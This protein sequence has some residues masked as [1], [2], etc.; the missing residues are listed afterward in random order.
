M[1]SEIERLLY[2]A[3]DFVMRNFRSGAARAAQKRRAQRKLG[4]VLRR[5][6]R[7]G[8]LLV[9]ILAG[10]VAYSIIVAPI[11]LLTWLVAIP[12]AFLFAFL[13]LFWPTRARPEAE[14]EAAPAGAALDELAGRAADGL[15][16]RWEE[17]PG[18]A[19]SAAD[20]I[21]ARLHELQPHLAGLDRDAMLAGDARRLICRH[22]PKLVDSYLALPPSARA[23]GSETSRSFAESLGVVAQEFD[24][25]L[26]QC[27]RDRHLSFETQR[28]FI[29]S[30]YQ[31]DERLTGSD[32]AKH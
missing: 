30:R 16:D 21:V 19:L 5:L 29:E 25:L 8:L 9:A 22:L 17:L 3:E 7:S 4:E 23:P 13:A 12:T 14:A 26:D 31:E 32:D 24:H 1:A 18:R 15:L 6:R 28:R 10:L 11:G 2:Q 20:S 27:C